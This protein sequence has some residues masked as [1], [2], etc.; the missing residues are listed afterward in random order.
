M[1]A[2]SFRRELSACPS[3]RETLG[4]YF[5]VRMAQLAHR[6]ACHRFHVVEARLARWLLAAQD[7]ARSDTLRITHDI[8]ALLLGVRRVGITRAATALQKRELI[9]YHRGCV[10]IVDR[11]GLEESACACYAADREIY[12]RI[13]A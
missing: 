3:L 5:H 11:A 9:S 1:D 6:A 7:R 13:L 10:T 4:R 8:L 2:Q 12:R